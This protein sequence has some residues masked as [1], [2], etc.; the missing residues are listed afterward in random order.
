MARTRRRRGTRRRRRRRRPRVGRSLL[1]LS[2]VIRMKYVFLGQIPVETAGI[3]PFT[4][5][6]RANGASDPF[7]GFGQGQ[8]RGWDQL[9][10]L[11]NQYCVL[12]SKIR[13][14]FIHNPQLLPTHGVVNYIQLNT[15]S[16]SG[17][18][19]PLNARAALESRLVTARTW[20]QGQ[21][22]IGNSL[23]KGFS[24]KK[25]FRKADVI[26]DPHMSAFTTSITQG[27]PVTGAFFNISFASTHGTPLG[28]CDIVVSIFYTIMFSD[29]TTPPESN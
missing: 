21:G 9:V 6:F 27:L 25:F 16:H 20:A 5:S 1:G 14:S 13:C 11:W 19:S 22:T 17:S 24:A 8:P 15:T 2:R 18:A 7:V 23:T 12:G 29:P 4:V 10:P 3:L 28:P 26:D